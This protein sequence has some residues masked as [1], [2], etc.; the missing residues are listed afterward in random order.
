MYELQVL[1]RRFQITHN[2][3]LDGVLDFL[4]S[5][6]MTDAGP[7]DLIDDDDSDPEEGV[8]KQTRGK[9]GYDLPGSMPNRG[10]PIIR[11]KCLRIAPTGRSFAAATTE[12]VLVY[13][14]DESF[15]FDPTDLDIDVTPEVSCVLFVKCCE[16]S[17]SLVFFSLV[18]TY[19]GEFKAC[20]IRLSDDWYLL[21]WK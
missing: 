21:S 13:S 12:G 3:S 17:K 6:K 14:I 2:L 1:L 18:S 19:H 4:N 10:R 16:T 20:Y 5:K 8:D 7:L 9:L 11:T 15:I